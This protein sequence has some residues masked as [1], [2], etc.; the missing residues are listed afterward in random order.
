MLSFFLKSKQSQRKW[1]HFSKKW[2]LRNWLDFQKEHL[3]PHLQSSFSYHISKFLT[4]FCTYLFSKPDFETPCCHT[5]TS[6][7]YSK[8]HNWPWKKTKK[9]EIFSRLACATTE[10]KLLWVCAR[11]QQSTERHFKSSG[12]VCRSK[13]Q[14]YG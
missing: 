9:A 7:L 10:A 4:N 3:N 2:G 11:I 12:T 8:G 1:Q 14:H 5:H 6:S 13:R